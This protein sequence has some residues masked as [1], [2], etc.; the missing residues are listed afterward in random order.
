MPEYL[1][2]KQLKAST[3]E[4]QRANRASKPSDSSGFSFAFF[5][6]SFTM[7]TV[8]ISYLTLKPTP[9]VGVWQTT[10]SIRYF[11]F[12]SFSTLRAGYQQ[13][14]LPDLFM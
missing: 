2:R 12:I 6:G 4:D 10:V 14:F 7:H 1:V 9:L 8:T 3:D 13:P 5:P 11:L